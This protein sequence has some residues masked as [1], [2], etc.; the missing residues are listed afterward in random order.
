MTLH[1]VTVGEWLAGIAGVALLVV[2]FVPWY[3]VVD[4]RHVNTT[5]SHVLRVYAS[6]S[7]WHALSVILAFVLVSAALGIALL[8]TTL[9]ER[10]PA[11]PTAVAVWGLVFSAVTALLV[12]Y[13]LL[14]PPGDASVRWGAVA[15]L[16]CAVAVAAGA[17]LALRRDVR[18]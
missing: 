2:T 6:Q 13:R 16:V 4:G 18:P 17:W 11:I 1:R 8:A 3:A 9:N 14:D 5:H 10:S 12:A 15:G 7:A